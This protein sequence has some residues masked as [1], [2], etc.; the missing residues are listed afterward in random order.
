[1]GST[2]DSRP[3]KN[4]SKLPSLD[5]ARFIA[6]L[7]V[8]AFH[9]TFTVAKFSGEVPFAG[10]F[11]GGHAGVE[12]FFVLSG[13]II[14]Y[15]HQQDFS[16]PGTIWLYARKRA[17][18]ILPMLWLILIS[19]S[20]LRHTLQGQTTNSPTSL[21]TLILDMFLV[22]HEGS[23]TLGV[24]WTLQRELVF[25]VIFLVALLNRRIGLATLFAWQLLVLILGA[26]KSLNSPIEIAVFDIHN[27]GF[28]I[29]LLIALFSKN[30][31]GLDLKLFLVIG[32]CAFAFLMFLEFKLGG[33][34]DPD[35]R[36]LGHRLSPVLYS[37][38]AAFCLMGLLSIDMNGVGREYKLISVLGGSSY[39]LYL[40]HGPVGSV[41]IRLTSKMHFPPNLSFLALIVMPVFVAIVLHLWIEK[42]ILKA[43]RPRNISR[44]SLA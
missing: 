39:V 33:P 22:P 38:A 9:A 42:P 7:L 32:L 40:V 28:G 23:L 20:L 44:V 4:N 11:R 27:L 29:G 12:Y 16:K 3:S 17:A 18:R 43:L 26:T 21:S 24:T 19:W 5:G 37:T 13:F 25:Y 30:I 41:V 35:F 10:A 31:R 36:P 1:M 34:L 14:F 15:A 6:A 2:V 8:T